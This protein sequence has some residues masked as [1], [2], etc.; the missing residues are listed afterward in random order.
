MDQRTVLAAVGAGAFLLFLFA[1][2]PARVA[3]AWFAPEGTRVAGPAGT[4]WNGSATA[5]SVGNVRLGATSW[6]MA[7]SRLLLGRLAG[8]VHTQAG[9]A[10]A[11]GT[12]AI[13]FSGTMS[14]AACRFEGPASTLQ[15][16]VPGVGALGGHLQLDIEALE[17]R[18]HWPVSAIATAKLSRMPIGMPGAVPGPAAAT[19]DFTATLSADPVPESGELLVDVADAGGPLQLTG[20]LR[21]TPPGNYEFAGRAKARADASPDLVNALRVLGRQASDGST[22]IAASGSF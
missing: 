7:P 14:C 4:L 19:G 1:L 22:E 15:A 11:S 21:I 10:D 9:E 17:L 18:E 8:E 20:S 5:I 12:L 16:F 2:F 6:R 3:I 13:G